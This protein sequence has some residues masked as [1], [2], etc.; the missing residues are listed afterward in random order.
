M[1]AS[2]L[3]TL[4][5]IADTFGN[6]HLATADGELLAGAYRRHPAPRFTS[7][8]TLKQLESAAKDSHEDASIAFATCFSS[9]D[10][11]LDAV[12]LSQLEQQVTTGRPAT[13]AAHVLS[14]L[15]VR[16]LGRAEIKQCS[17]AAA[18]APSQAKRARVVK[19]GPKSEKAKPR[20]A[21]PAA[22]ASKPAETKPAEAKP[23]DVKSAD[24]ETADAKPADAK[25]VEAAE[26]EVKATDAKSAETDGK[27]AAEPKAV[28]AGDTDAVST[29]PVPDAEKPATTETKRQ[30]DTPPTEA[31]PTS[32]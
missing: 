9:E 17:A 20:D 26:P 13:G 16:R 24:G 2:E 1:L 22:E 12:A 14:T 27:P 3:S 18:Q 23:S 31:K 6:G 11:K 4:F 29:T 30:A 28:P 25:P 19:R 10:F 5:R 32:A 21:K 15:R 8:V 7:A